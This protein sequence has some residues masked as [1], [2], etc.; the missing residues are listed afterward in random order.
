[1]LVVSVLGM[2]GRG[3]DEPDGSCLLINQVAHP[4][5]AGDF[6]F[7][8]FEIAAIM[9]ACGQVAAQPVLTVWVGPRLR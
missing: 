5:A 6:I 3:I 9:P 4:A 1:M 2:A 7:P 8:L